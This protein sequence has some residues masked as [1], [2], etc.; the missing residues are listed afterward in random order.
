VKEA[1]VNISLTE[2]GPLRYF[3]FSQFSDITR[4]PGYGKSK[5]LKKQKEKM[6]WPP[7]SANVGKSVPLMAS[8]IHP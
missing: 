5:I 1:S 4:F 8:M 6:I 3:G 7:G 2:E